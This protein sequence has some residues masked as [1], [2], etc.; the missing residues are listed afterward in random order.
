MKFTA[1]ATILAASAAVAAPT[2]SKITDVLVISSAIKYLA[3]P[4]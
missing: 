2:A 1:A 4:Q 3:D